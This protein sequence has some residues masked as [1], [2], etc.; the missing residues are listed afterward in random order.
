MREAQAGFFGPRKHGMP[1]GFHEALSAFAFSVRGW[2]DPLQE[3]TDVHG[4]DVC[5]GCPPRA[6]GDLR[7]GITFLEGCPLKIAT[8]RSE[9]T[10]HDAV[11]LE[12]ACLCARVA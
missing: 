10:P 4:T 2:T 1:L 12:H 5:T 8:M 6:P 3:V 11:A 9:P 7:E